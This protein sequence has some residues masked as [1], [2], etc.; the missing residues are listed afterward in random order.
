MIGLQEKDCGI[1]KETLTSVSVVPPND[2]DARP[3][4]T[5]DRLDIE[6]GIRRAH[7][8]MAEYVLCVASSAG[9]AR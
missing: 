7:E 9:R 6:V 2:G 1:P 5:R 8:E 4:A 3:S